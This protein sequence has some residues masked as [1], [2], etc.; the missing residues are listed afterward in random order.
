MGSITFCPQSSEDLCSH[1]QF[2]F[3]KLTA[4]VYTCGAST[5]EVDIGTS[6]PISSAELASSG[7]SKRFESYLK[8]IKSEQ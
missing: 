4:T 1:S 5:G 2:P 3:E 7:F 8:K 6:R